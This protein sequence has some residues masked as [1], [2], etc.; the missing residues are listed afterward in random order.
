MKLFLCGG[1]CEQQ[2]PNVYK[3]LDEVIDNSKP[4]LRIRI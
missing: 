1:E 3:K 2:K 4:I